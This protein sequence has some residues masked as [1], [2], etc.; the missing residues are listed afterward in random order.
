MAKRHKRTRAYGWSILAFQS[1][2]RLGLI[3]LA[4]TV[5]A[6]RPHRS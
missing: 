3:V 4:G 6:P 1:P 2:D 5:L